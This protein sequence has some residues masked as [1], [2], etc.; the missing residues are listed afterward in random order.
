MEDYVI[1]ILLYL[2]VQNN[3]LYTHYLGMKK[4]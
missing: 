2:K 4:C 3:L 1:K